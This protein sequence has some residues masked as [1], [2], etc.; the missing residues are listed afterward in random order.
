MNLLLTA[1]SYPASDQDW[2]GLFI[3]HMVESLA[4]RED[5]RLSFWGPPGPLPPSAQRATRPND[6]AFTQSLM[7]R[8]GI[9]HLLRH[10]PVQGLVAAFSLLRRQ[11]RTFRQSD[12]DIYHVN[13]LQNALALPD[14]RRPALVTVLGTDMRLL[15]LPGMRALLR[16]SFRRRTIAICP[17]ADWMLPALNEAFGDLATVRFVP[18]GIDPRWYAVERRFETSANPKWLCVS[19][20][21]ADKI[22]PLFEWTA[23]R[24]AGGR[25]ELHLF[26]PMQEQLELPPWV[27][28][29][30][31]A[32]PDDLREI[33]F[34]QA[35]GLITLS[36][37]A[38]GRPQ[39]MLEALASGLPIIASRLPAHDD[40]LSDRGGG[41]LCD[42][43][44]TVD[45]ALTALADPTTNRA[46]GMLGRARMLAEVG[47]WDDCAERYVSLYRFLQEHPHP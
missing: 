44:D 38:E 16:R 7:D 13:W 19:R 25:A 40:L 22:G 24:F 12:A 2:K 41:I 3:R 46:L 4:R 27:H 32:S 35:H 37:H 1:T 9:A 15:R 17:N 6:D 42:S 39:V 30:G 45:S 5:V 36:Q 33:W 18:F 34:P 31:P 21:T 23:P 29:H 43:P 10:R 8:G 26:G 11:S 28:W 14:D 20:L 47:T